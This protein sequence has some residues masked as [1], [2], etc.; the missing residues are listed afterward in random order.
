MRLRLYAAFAACLAAFPAS[1]AAGQIDLVFD[2]ARTEVDFAVG[3]VLHNFH[4]TFHLKSGELR[5]DPS[6]GWAGGELIVDTGTGNSGSHARDSRMHREILESA[7]YPEIKFCPDRVNGA[8]TPEGLSRLSVHGIFRIHGADHELTLPV[9]VRSA[10]GEYSA[11]TNFDV[12][13]VRWGMKNPSTLLL[14]VKDTAGISIRTVA[15][16]VRATQ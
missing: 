15:H 7:K 14:R 13:Y 1:A 5:F 11:T 3:S 9:E 4:G 16:A 10:G 6:S 8:F 12:P 2:P